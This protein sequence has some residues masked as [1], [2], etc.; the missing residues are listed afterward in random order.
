V[1][2]AIVGALLGGRLTAR[3][4]TKRVYLAGLAAGLVSMLVLALSLFVELD[5]A[6]AFPM[7]L[8]ATASLGA[9]FGVT[10]PA[11]NALLGLGTALAPFFVAVFLGLEVG[12]GGC[13]S[14]PSAPLT[15]RQLVT[16]LRPKAIKPTSVQG[17]RS[18]L[19]RLALA[20]GG[21][22]WQ[23]PQTLG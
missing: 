18:R 19:G 16:D 1:A 2:A 11:L 4:G 22:P 13:W 20:P 3:F 8:L 7:L 17:P 10:V 23:A 6:L 15:Y 9:S 5:R 21:R 14:I 12:A